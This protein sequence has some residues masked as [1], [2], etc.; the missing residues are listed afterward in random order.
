M[1]PSW[2]PRKTWPI[3]LSLALVITATATATSP[4]AAQPAGPDGA[5]P[6]DIPAAGTPVTLITGDRVWLTPAGDGR[7]AA[8]IDPAAR[9]GQQPVFETIDDGENV[10]IVPSDAASLIPDQLDRE[11]FNVTK[12]AQ[13]GY[14]EGVPVIVTGPAGAQARPSAAPAELPAGLSDPTNLPSIGGYAAT[15]SP[16]GQWWNAIAGTASTV[17]AAATALPP[18]GKV[19]LDE[20]ATVALAESVP[21]VG[22]PE[23]WAAGYDGTGVTVAVLDTGIDDRHQDLA[24]KVVAA[25]NFTTEPDTSDQHGHGTHVAG[26]VAGTGAASGGTYTGVAPGAQLMSGKVCDQFGNCPTSGLIAGMEWAAPQADVISVSIGTQSGSDGTDPISQAVN[27]LTAQHD[28]L[29]VIAAGN[30]GTRG[31]G[32][33]GSPGAADA[34]LTV[35]SVDKNGDL[36]STSSRGPRLGDFAIKPDLTAPGVGIV[37][38]RAEGTTLGPIVDEVYTQLSGTSMATPHVSGAAAILLQQDAELAAAELKSALATTATPNPELDVYQQGGG[39]LDIPAALATPV[40]A[41]P[42]PLNL[43]YFPYPQE[44]TDPVS[45]EV[46]YTNRSD[47]EVSLALSVEL[48]GAEG[49]PL[50]AGAVTVEPAT[51]TVPA[52]GSATA[53]VTLDVTAVELGRY[54]GYL[55][56]AGE[57][58]D[59][60]RIPTGFYKE[61][62][63]YNLSVEGYARDGRPARG[64]STIHVLN[65]DDRDAFFELSITYVDGV[66]TVRVPPGTYHVMGNIFTYDGNNQFFQDRTTVGVSEVEVTGDTTV[67]LDAREAV[68]VQIATPAHADAAPFGFSRIGFQRTDVDGDGISATLTGDWSPTYALPTDPVTKGE[69]EYFVRAR[70]GDPPLVLEVAEPEPTELHPREMLG[71]P[72]VDGELALPLVW[73]G[74]GAEADY[75]GVDATGAAVL[76]MRGGPGHADKEAIA[77]AHGAAALLVM[78]NAAGNYAG[79]VGSAAEIPAMT[80]SGEEGELLRDL[81]TAGPVTLALSGTPFTPYLYDLVYAEPDRI[82]AAL[83]YTA[84]PDQLATVAN[85]FHSGVPD[86]LMGEVRHSWRPFENLSIGIVYPALAP[87]E[88]LELLTAGDTRYQQNLAAQDPSTGVMNEP[89]TRYQAGEHRVQPWFQSPVRPGVLEGS[90]DL[91]G[92]PITRTG[93]TL[94]LFIP[95][96]SDTGRGH[97]GFVDGATDTAA[98]R[99]YQDGELVLEAPNARREVVVDPNPAD[100]RLELDVTRQADW[101][102]TSVATHTAWTIADSSRPPTGETEVLPL[103]LVDYDAGL[104]LTNTASRRILP[105]VDIQLRH[106]PGADGPA[107]HYPRVSVSYDG[108]DHWYPGL[109]LPRRGDKYTVLFLAPLFPPSDAEF[110]SLRVEARDTGGNRIEQEIINAWRIP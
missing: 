32:S 89:I 11:L 80:V 59:D 53:T 70:L 4:A 107:I 52:G 40:L 92:R 18:A 104:D 67:V 1:R 50:P 109:V 44:G 56:A 22:A 34:A 41:T 105:T 8:T 69:F 27:T 28:T 58:F 63:M 42:S 94:A 73:A 45:T 46:T 95:E 108:G 103:L 19:W 31:E 83:D 98:F 87:M 75:E 102:P 81:L 97:W 71:S 57:G 15:V 65:V 9:T 74:L 6:L 38:A 55:V 7:M 60:I 12:L 61:P 64:S 30:A 36:A 77:R 37:S 51:L 35:G 110:A 90:A 106:Q 100:Y 82:P 84:D 16:D 13:Y 68:P 10:Y 39:L 88:R 76:T 29:F 25:E 17:G 62:E 72:P 20:L 99:L 26:I 78:N 43:G 14:T 21:M 54:G 91:A 96:W 66:A 93:D 48:T 79:S 101:W 33:V 49:D 85:R 24:G 2:F 47:A 86:Q 3:A 5:A 23:A